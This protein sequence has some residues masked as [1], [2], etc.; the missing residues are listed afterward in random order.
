MV[1]KITPRK[2]ESFKN[3][4]VKKT[5]PSPSPKRRGVVEFL[6]GTVI[7]H[8]IADKKGEIEYIQSKE[9]HRS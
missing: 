7:L 6:S 1:Y 5:S 4:I 8:S 9:N 2:V 3:A